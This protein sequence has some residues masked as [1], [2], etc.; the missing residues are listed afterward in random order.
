[1]LRFILLCTI[2]LLV[3]SGCQKEIFNQ[4]E[5][6]LEGTW[7]FTKAK[8]RPLDNLGPFESVLEQYS[9][10]EITFRNDQTVLYSKA[11]GDQYE[12]VWDLHTVSGEDVQYILSFVIDDDNQGLIQYVWETS[13]LWGDHCLTV[14][15]TTSNYDFRYDLKKQ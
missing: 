13:G 4:L 6:R 5:N 8:H 9:G 2:V 1:M 15:G 10:D 12:G 11:N 7:Y 14:C 3:G